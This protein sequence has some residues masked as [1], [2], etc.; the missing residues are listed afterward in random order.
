MI[1]R[2]CFQT[3]IV[4]KEDVQFGAS[5]NFLDNEKKSP[6]FHF[7]EAIAW[8]LQRSKSATTN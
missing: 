4:L 1:W 5:D 7:I 2:Q 3:Q 8:L 6:A